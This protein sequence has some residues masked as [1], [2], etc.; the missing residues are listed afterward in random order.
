ME[1]TIRKG[2]ELEETMSELKNNHEK[3]L[4]SEKMASL[5]RLTAGIAHEM[6]SPLAAAR[7]SLR[8]LQTLIN[9]YKTSINEPDITSKDHV[10]ISEDMKKSA[11]LAEMSIEKASSFIKGI[12][13]Q[14]REM[15]QQEGIDFNIVDVINEALPLLGF[16]LRKNNLTIDFKYSK[17]PIEL[18]G[19]PGRFSYIITNLVTNAADA[20]EDKKNEKINI[21][22]TEEDTNII[23][24]VED[25]GC[26][27]PESIQTKIF[28]PLFTTK[29]FG[30]GTGLGLTIIHDIVYGEFDGIIEVESEINV[31]TTFRII[32]NKA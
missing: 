26:G 4:I 30:Q 13:S 18:F 11:S 12:K 28:D 22:L 1:E 7:A 3:L 19:L 2:K 21:N 14:T 20:M 27:I 31:G 16:I 24:S 23:L 25:K 10:E 9:E 29:P 8:E 5:G 6:N 32:F 15:D 17:N